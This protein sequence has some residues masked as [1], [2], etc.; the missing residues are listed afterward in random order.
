MEYTQLG[1]T[2]VRVSRL[3]FGAMRLPMV[4]VGDEQYVDMDRAVE[5]FHRAFELGVT[6]VD[7]AF[8]YC[9][10]QSEFAVGRA[11]RG[12]RDQVVLT[13]KATKQRMA[14]QGDLRR[15]LD[16]Q[17]QRLEV[18]YLDFYLFHGIGLENFHEFDRKGGWLADMMRARD[19]GL[20]RH[21]G[22]SFHDKPE[23]LVRLVDLGHF[24]ML[25][26]Q[27]NYLDRKNAE[28]MAYARER[29]LGVVVM[30]PVGGGRLAGLPGFLSGAAGLDTSHAAQLALR[31]VLANPNVDV[32]LSGM[33]SREMV[34]ENVAAVEAGPLSE[35]EHEALARLLE[36]T[37]QLAD[38]YCT[39]CGY[40]MPCPQGVDIPGRFA[41]MNAFKVYRMEDHARRSYANVRRREAKSEG[42]GTC[43][44][45]RE[46][47]AKCTQEIA[48]VDQLRETDAALAEPAAAAAA[49]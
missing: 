7:T 39:G 21:V 19:E 20:V 38:L 10:Q 8:L 40:C 48:I 44:E 42:Q 9:S 22:F 37:R 11:L 1:R 23:G 3:G 32:A 35:D 14:R 31:F 5:A 18:D 47:E 49:T 28:A 12:R 15:M 30:G 16:H 2:G 34:E 27:Y 36:E 29:G 17:L 26:C 33:G 24:E 41:A 46:C 25:T 6:Y 4:Q 45:C 13:T 43:I